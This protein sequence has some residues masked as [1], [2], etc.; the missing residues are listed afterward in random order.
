MLGASVSLSFPPPSSLTVKE[1]RLFLWQLVYQ[2]GLCSF[3]SAP[4]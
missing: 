1:I 3:D 4:W 2:T